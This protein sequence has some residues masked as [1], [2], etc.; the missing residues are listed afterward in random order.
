MKV[1]LLTVS[2]SA[3]F[4]ELSRVGRALKTSQ[5]YKP[6][7]WFLSQYPTLSRDI[8]MCRSE[9][10]EFVL[11][12]PP[13]A[14]DD[15]FVR[16]LWK[17]LASHL[18]PFWYYFKRGL[19]TE[20]QRINALVEN[21]ISTVQQHEPD[22]LVVCEENVGYATHIQIRIC[23]AQQIPTVIIPYT[24]ANATEAAEYLYNSPRCHVHG[25]LINRF[26]A[27]KFPHWVYEHRGRKLLRLPAVTIIAMEESGYGS[28]RP[29]VL[30]SGETAVIAVESEHMLEYYRSE[31]LYE[32]RLIVTGA[33]Y[34]DVLAESFQRSRELR[35]QLVAELDLRADL[36]ILLCALPPSQ[37]PRDCEF[38]NYESLLSFWMESL[39]QIE[40]WNV[41]IRPHPRV[42]DEQINKLKRFGVKISG[43]N[44]ASL[45]PLCD[46]YVASVSATIRWAI[47]CGKP[48][49]NYDVYQ[50]NYSDYKNV[51]GVLTVF[52]KD[53]FRDTINRLTS[54]SAYYKEISALQVQEMSKWGC[55]DGKSSERMLKLFDDLIDGK[56]RR[57]IN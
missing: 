24:I 1:V 37:F 41:I 12:T 42:T 14:E 5:K 22:L 33:L 46:L 4:V 48:V 2:I 38:A 54:D 17:K 57:R 45:V 10:W 15:T 11:P 3:H 53:T 27:R 32:D 31:N 35:E 13:P 36:P 44:T 56:I 19:T 49:V 6:V 55:L 25:S 8:E 23:H 18:L 16:T 29:W 20:R 30:N 47:A 43:W 52:S 51:G 39:S 9:G 28:S 40:G 7:F 50:M 26:I 34:D 21:T